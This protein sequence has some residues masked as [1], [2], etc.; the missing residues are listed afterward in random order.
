MHAAVP[1]APL[2]AAALLAAAVLLPSAAAAPNARPLA[3]SAPARQWAPSVVAQPGAHV[4]L[5]RVHWGSAGYD[6]LALP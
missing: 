4:P 2:A 3:P 1:H 5:P 6:R